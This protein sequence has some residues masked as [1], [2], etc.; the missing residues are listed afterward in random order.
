MITETEGIVLR[1]VKAANGRRMLQ[2]FTKKYGKI[3]V[4]ASLTEGGRNKSA[5]AVRPFTRGQY[6][7]YRGR[8]AY[9]LNQ[10]QTLESFYTIG[11]DLDR[12]MAASYM[13]ELTEKLLPEEMPQPRLYE[14][15]LDTLRELVHRQKK[16]ETLLMAYEVKTLDILGSMP[17]LAACVS[18]GTTQDLRYFSTAEGGMLCASCAEKLPPDEKRLIYAPKFDIV[19]V[20]EYLQKQPLSALRGLAL[21]DDVL[22]ALQD[23]LRQYMAYHLDIKELKSEKFFREV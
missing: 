12:Y 21:T 10:A 3:S 6:E 7:L 5:L 9:D 11:E 15:L 22:H 16:Q 20:L 2:V 13:L 8:D 14:L 18:C 4:G 17:R 19:K 23:I 1:Q